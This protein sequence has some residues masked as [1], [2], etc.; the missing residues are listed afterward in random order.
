LRTRTVSI[1]PALSR[2]ETVELW[3]LLQKVS[4]FAEWL[5]DAASD[6]VDTELPVNETHELE[7]AVFFHE[8]A[9]YG[10][11]PLTAGLPASTCGQPSSIGTPSIAAAPLT[12]Y[13]NRAET[14]L[15]NCSSTSC[16]SVGS[17]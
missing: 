7:R 2:L 15:T 12:T 3:L 17:T 13:G 9:N 8:P 6:G 11:D 5:V 10:I 1:L 16:R 4:T 14:C